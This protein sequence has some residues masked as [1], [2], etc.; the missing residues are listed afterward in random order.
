MNI[1]AYYRGV[2][3]KCQEIFQSSLKESQSFGNAHH[4]S[5]CIFDFSNYITDYHE[6]ELIGTVSSQ[7]E[8]A[9]LN[10]GLG[11]YRQAFST[12]R[13]ALEMGLGVAYFSIH[14]L[15]HTEWLKGKSDIRWAKLVDE[16]D[17]VLSKRFVNAF[18]PELEGFA[19]HYLELT[20]KTYRT[21]SEFVHGNY[22]TWVKSGIVI[23]I[24]PEL[25]KSYFDLFKKVSEILLF[26][27]CC[28][29]LK[30]FPASQ[31]DS[32]EFISEELNFIGPIR[33]FMGGPKEL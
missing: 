3:S 19:N 26:V 22:Q 33:E 32:M 16:G 21:L 20:T 18:F 27:L 11:L 1:E 30:S 7:L 13:L 5:A 2:N 9:T 28:R 29:Y 15:E 6:K 14:K 17:G 10:L 4:L 23:K 8:A 24:S 25:I 12:L 31:L